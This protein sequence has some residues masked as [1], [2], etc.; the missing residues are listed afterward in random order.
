MKEG[1]DRNSET[2]AWL[3]RELGRMD[4]R[5]LPSEANFVMID[6]GRDVKPVITAMRE[7]NVRVGRKFPALPNHMRVTI[8]TPDEMK[9]FVVVLRETLGR[10]S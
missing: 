2:K 9:R 3:A 4:I 6:V 7:R 10:E 5:Q 1:R 8:G